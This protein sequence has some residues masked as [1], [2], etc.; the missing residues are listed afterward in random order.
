MLNSKDFLL[1]FLERKKNVNTINGISYGVY[2]NKKIKTNKIQQFKNMTALE[3]CQQCKYYKICKYGKLSEF[4]KEKIFENNIKC[5]NLYFSINR[6]ATLTTIRNTTT[7]KET[8][9]TF[10]EKQKM[11]Q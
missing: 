3:V 6:K 2:L 5:E 8:K 10:Q 4:E 1:F 9:K 7:G 11:K